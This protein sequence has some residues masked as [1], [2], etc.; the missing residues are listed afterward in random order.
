MDG[1]HLSNATLVDWGRRDRKGAWD[2]FDASGYAA[3]LRRLRSGD[4]EVVHAP[5]FDRDLDEPLAAAIAVRR[6][7]PLVVAE[8]NYLLS[9]HGDWPRVAPLLDESWYLD[10]DD[11]TRQQ[12]LVSRH[13][14]HGMGHEQAVA[15][16]LG[17]DQANAAVVASS[18]E[19][20]DH[21]WT[22]TA[23]TAPTPT[24]RDAP[25]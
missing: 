13:Q 14:R 11:A 2:T 20:A 6:E 15:W 23:A 16:T 12:R 18:R 19:R 5:D 7:V 1:F 10:V 24:P 25:V 4:D 17:T 21:V 22:L 8:G 3:L 9:D